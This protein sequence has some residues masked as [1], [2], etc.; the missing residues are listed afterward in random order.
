MA[1]P[2]T[3]AGPGLPRATVYRWFAALLLDPPGADGLA[4]YRSAE[5]RALLAALDAVPGLAEAV[6]DIRALVAPGM[7][8]AAAAA[9]LA[10][11]HARAFLTGGPR[12][13]PPYASVWLSPRGLLYQEPAREMARLLRAAGLGLPEGLRDAPDHL[14]LML[15]FMAELAEREAAGQPVPLAPAAFLRDRLLSWV[16]AFA[17]RLGTGRAL[18]P[19][20]GLGRALEAF[21]RADLAARDATIPSTPGR[22]RSLAPAGVTTLETRE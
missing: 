1:A 13:A 14:A 9:A 20:A 5:G 15:G 7:D 12:A 4:A 3:D 16:P 19:Y 10:A 11:A 18:G 2:P 6:G 8:P 22:C 17:A 21:L